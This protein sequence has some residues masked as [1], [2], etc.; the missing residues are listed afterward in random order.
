MGKKLSYRQREAVNGSNKFYDASYFFI[1]LVRLLTLSLL[2][3]FL[4][5]FNSVILN[6]IHK[7]T[8]LIEFFSF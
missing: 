3:I 8:S 6:Y 5:I 2:A 1:F 4:K 7:A